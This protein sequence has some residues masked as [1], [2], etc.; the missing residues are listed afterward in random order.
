MPGKRATQFAALV[1]QYRE[2]LKLSRDEVIGFF[3]ASSEVPGFVRTK[4]R[5]IIQRAERKAAKGKP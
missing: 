3:A 4:A 1:K 2:E 5:R